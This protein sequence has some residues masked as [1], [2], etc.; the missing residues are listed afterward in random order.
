MSQA[1]KGDAVKVHYT[2]TLN[3]GTVFDSSDGREPI[4]FE[5][6][7]QEVIPGFE[8]GVAGM[9]VGETKNVTIPAADAYGERDERLVI[10]MQRERLPDDVEPQIGQQFRLRQ[11]EQEFVV[12]VQSIGDETVSFD[13]NHPLAGKDLTFELELVDI[14]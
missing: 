9:E 10:E 11:G 13:A 4:A 8:N 2:G 14:G 7:K 12:Q 6:G 3:D 5:I 1:K